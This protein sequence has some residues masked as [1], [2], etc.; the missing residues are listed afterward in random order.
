MLRPFRSEVLELVA[1]HHE[2]SRGF[3]EELHC[4]E[5]LLQINDLHIFL[6]TCA[7]QYCDVACFLAQTMLPTFMLKVN[8]VE[9]AR[10]FAQA[11]T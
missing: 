3:V 5:A 6:F 1:V 8:I 7:G 2:L 10:T 9:W 11:L 4:T